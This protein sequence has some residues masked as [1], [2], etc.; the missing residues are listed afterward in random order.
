MFESVATRNSL[1][2]KLL[3]SSSQTLDSLLKSG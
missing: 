3:Q 2:V 1:E